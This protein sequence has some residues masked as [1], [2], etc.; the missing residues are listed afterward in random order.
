MMHIT[1]P[2]PTD[3]RARLVFGIDWRAYPVKGGKAER[4]RYADTFGATHYVEFKVGTDLIGGFAMPD[5]PEVKGTRLYSGAARVA[6][7][8]RIKGRDAALVLLQD[9]QR[10]YVV[11][12]VR[13]AVR[14]DEVLSPEA[15]LA[16]RLEIEQECLKGN[17]RL[18]TLGTGDRIGDVDEPFQASELLA[19]RKVGRIAKLPMSVPTFI[20]VAAIVVGAFFGVPKLLDVLS[21]PPPPPRAPTF[22]EQYAVAVRDVFARMQPRA[23]ELGPALLTAVGGKETVIKGWVF[24]EANCPA[25]GFC[26]MTFRRH[27]GSFSGFDQAATADMRPVTFARDGRTLA[28]RGPTIPKAASLMESESKN[29]PAE[30]A[31]IDMLQTPPQ[32]MSVQPLE[33]R[34]YGYTVTLAEARPLIAPPGAGGHVGRLLKQGDWTIEGFRWQSPLLA[35]LPPNMAL[36]SLKVELRLNDGAGAT[37]DKETGD[38]PYG[39]H[40][41]AKGKY[42]VFD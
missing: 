38:S 7:H 3:K 22:A 5:A 24:H 41:T 6:L 36:E 26:T 37:T 31:F 9:G 27:G 18:D 20:P 40:F 15:A 30:Q 12:V 19:N 28:S 16:R 35:K 23:S 39:V 29:W 21:P 42:Y 8:D 1:E 4:R 11:Y 33:L 2:L 13:G 34:A 17:L 14:N 32:R 10:V 25:S